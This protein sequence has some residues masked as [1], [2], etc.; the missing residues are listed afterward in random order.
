M[1]DI[2]SAL[3]AFSDAHVCKWKELQPKL[4]GIDVGM[5]LVNGETRF[6]YVTIQIASKNHKEMVILHSQV[7]ELHSYIKPDQLLRDNRKTVYSKILLQK[8]QD[9]KGNVLESICIQAN[10]MEDHF[11]N[12]LFDAMLSEVADRADLLEELH[13][14]GDHH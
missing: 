7:G 3:N 9:K 2:K 1:I 13:Y 12:A 14:G 10:L 6:Q 5:Q 11:T 4:Y 8:L